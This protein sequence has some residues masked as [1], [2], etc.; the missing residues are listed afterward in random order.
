MTT[1]A[2]MFHRL[3]KISDDMAQLGEESQGML[4]MPKKLR[5]VLT[6]PPW[7][8]SIIVHRMDVA[9]LGTTTGK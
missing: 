3:I 7:P 1:L 9:T 6:R 2:P 8:L 5:N 4:G